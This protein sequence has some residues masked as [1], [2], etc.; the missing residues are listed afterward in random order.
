[1]SS[2][3]WHHIML[4]NF[5]TTE[6]HPDNNWPGDGIR[7]SVLKLFYV[8]MYYAYKPSLQQKKQNWLLTSCLEPTKGVSSTQSSVPKGNVRQ[9]RTLKFKRYN[10]HIRILSG[11]LL[12]SSYQHHLLIPCS[13]K[14]WSY[15]VYHTHNSEPVCH[16][17]NEDS[18][19]KASQS[20]FIRK[21]V[22]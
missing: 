19:A 21:I 13:G 10:T 9:C 20:K 22:Y 6:T 16:K 18:R 17:N 4:C 14:Y 8:D 12:E 7:H 3:F 1:M 15:Y 2:P 5:C 11:A